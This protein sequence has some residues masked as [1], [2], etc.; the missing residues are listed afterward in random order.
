MYEELSDEQLEDSVF[1]RYRLMAEKNIENVPEPERTLMVV[2]GAHGV[3]GNGGFRY[4][5]ESNFVAKQPYKLISE[6]YKN[7]GLLEHGN[8]ILKLTSLFPNGEPHKDLKER[9]T[10]II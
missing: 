2:Y 3:I 7:L 1:E 9:N 10:Q 8:T 6:S 5:F 4:F